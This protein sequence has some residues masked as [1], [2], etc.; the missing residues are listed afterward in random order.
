MTRL[1]V[2]VKVHLPATVFCSHDNKI[3]E[4][5]TV[6]SE[7]SLSG[8]LLQRLKFDVQD[9][10]LTIKP[11]S[12]NLYGIWLTG[13]VV[14]QFNGK[15]AVKLIEQE[16]EVQEKLW[17]YVKENLFITDRCPY[18]NELNYSNSEYCESCHGYLNFQDQ[19]YINK[20]LKETFVK[21]LQYY[22]SRLN[23]EQ[24]RR[25]LHFASTE[26][27]N[28]RT[29][30]NSH[31]F[32]GESEGMK[33]V[34]S[35]INKVALTDMNILLLGQ[36][37]TGKELTAKTIHEKSFQKHAPFVTVNCAAIPEGLLETELFGYEKGAFTGAYTNKQGK[38]DMAEDGTLF[39]D[40][41][42]DMSLALQA[43][44]LRFLQEKVIERIGSVK[45][46]KI[47]VRF[48]A[49]TNIDIHT[50]V[51]EG[52]F[53]SDLYYRLDEFTITLPPVRERENDSVILAKHFL[54]T[55]SLQINKKILLTKESIDAIRNYNWPGN[56]REIMNKV[57]RAVV[58]AENN[59]I[60][61]EDLSLSKYVNNI[62]EQNIELKEEKEHIERQMLIKALKKSNNNISMTSKILGLSRPTVYNLK[63]K[64][65]L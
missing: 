48:I 57:K 36:S 42:G 63:R 5:D 22:A 32:I 12:C 44:I 18:C 54:K 64:Y 35:L 21:R 61:P 45:T 4:E 14:R 19:A 49:A 27:I 8:V 28:R 65:L 58:L 43:K 59:L 13:E 26:F 34:Y 23:L 25:V 24:S 50:A 52:Q 55:F 11:E 20:H 56:V 31:R 51:K 17:Q 40:E 33:K 39:L 2:R 38:I 30:S 16:R 60:Q 37:G 3:E 15:S 1:D 7:L 9:R 41:I 10:I 47:N 53:R 29:N 46:K 6:I 62:K